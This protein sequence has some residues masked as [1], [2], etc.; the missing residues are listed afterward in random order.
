[1][2]SDIRRKPRLLWLSADCPAST[3]GD[4]HSHADAE[5]QPMTN[6]GPALLAQKGL[7]FGHGVSGYDPL[8]R[9]GVNTSRRW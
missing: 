9:D 4:I 3:N 1:M 8:K 5:Q 2:L 6:D 7:L